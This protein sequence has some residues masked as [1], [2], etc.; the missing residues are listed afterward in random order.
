MAKII[1]QCGNCGEEREVDEKMAGSTLA[2][3]GCGET[4]RIPLPDIGE[5]VVLGGFI[6]EKLL[7]FGAMGEVWLAHQQ[8][9]DRKVAL[10][11]LSREF[12]M[13]SQ[14]VDRFLKEVR[15]S[16]KMDH[17]NIITAFDAG[18]DNDIYYLAISFVDGVDLDQRLAE[19]ELLPE[20]EALKI[21]REIASALCYAWNDFKIL[22][23][24][25]KPSN[26]MIDKK[27]SAKLMD[28]GISKSANE[29]AQL[30]MT[31]TVIGTPYYMS[32][33]Q[34]MGEKELDCR[35]DIYSLG[36]TLYHLVTGSL[37]FEATT[38]IGIIS[39]HITEPL[40]P[41]QDFNPNLSDACTALLETMM[42][43][44]PED[45]QQTWEEVIDDIDNVL[46]GKMP[47][48]NARPAPG[49]SI[50]MPAV[51]A[52]ELPP[53]AKP[54][55]IVPETESIT[56]S[57][58]TSK[59]NI[60]D[61]SIETP[62]KPKSKALLISIVSLAAVI[63]F[64]AA[65]LIVFS[66]GD[67]NKKD[68]NQQAGN[69]FPEEFKPDPPP[70]KPEP[71]TENPPPPKINPNLKKYEDMWKFAIK[72]A[73]DNPENYDLAINNFSEISRTAA[74]SKY[75]LMADVK[76]SELEKLKANAINKVMVALQQ[77]IKPFQSRKDYNQV[78]DIYINYQGPWDQETLPERQ[79]LHDEYRK[80]ADQFEN[81]K[82][83][84][85]NRQRQQM[86]DTVNQIFDDIIEGKM[87]SA[88]LKLT[89]A[90][91]N[92]ML[93]GDIRE[94]LEQLLN[95]GENLILSFKKDIG[96]KVN[97]KLNRG[98]L[99]NVTIKKIKGNTVYYEEKRGK[100]ITQRPLSLKKLD[101]SEIIKRSGMQQVAIN[102]FKSL[103]AAK[104]KDLDEAKKYG[105]RIQPREF[106]EIFK[107]AMERHYMPEDRHNE[108]P[109]GDQ[110]VVFNKKPFENKNKPQFNQPNNNGF[111]PQNNQNFRPKFNDRRSLPQAFKD[112][113]RKLT[114]I[115]PA[116][117][118]RARILGQHGRIEEVDL[119]ECH[120]RGITNESVKML[121]EIPNL[122]S[123]DLAQT[124]I[125]DIKPVA[126]TKLER[127]ILARCNKLKDLSPLSK[128]KNLKLLSLA[129]SQ[130]EDISPLKGLELQMLD[131]SRTKVKDISVLK[132]MPLKELR[133]MDCMI[134]DYSVLA[135]LKELELLEPKHLWRLVPGKEH[136][137]NQRIHIDHRNDSN[138]PRFHDNNQNFK[139]QPD[140]FEPKNNQ[141]NN[142]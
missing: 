30:T 108:N 94:P 6:L 58:A 68:D 106:R 99:K 111:N 29:E 2:C 35:S 112:V 31:G 91:T 130:I 34:G 107:E 81:H 137:A 74:G 42:G 10:K 5:G 57:M 138:L 59:P 53:H 128:V 100:V 120:G 11:L 70:E 15:M 67:D 63:A 124:K 38:A 56:P 69:N 97:L 32:P 129:E 114:K 51:N 4:I 117:N 140:N 7:G 1:I 45:R 104:I 62:D 133:M 21:I 102:L 89:K 73:N 134:N 93:P 48:S 141:P 122:R 26:I 13:D 80:K 79:R 87:K 90:S 19:I 113:H 46:L 65:G 131:I 60:A 126:E 110:Q 16:A 47:S 96:S 39:K 20:K 25:I 136:M 139:N 119:F 24:D 52:N 27:G 23:R 88:K 14:F 109:P 76:I 8:T 77:K 50:V 71:T 3:A 55:A 95:I 36:A 40:P 103:K 9:M 33:E 78:A 98:S 118:G 66:G 127:L 101:E 43:K 72:Y 18:C 44:S 17:P 105:E 41:P 37:P 86:R 61:Q 12:T 123:L 115:N 22:H 132:N 64:V 84:Q 54:T 82:Q 75:K 135:T 116:Y 121:C 142:W 28:M 49:D 92:V 125:T 83:D 85:H